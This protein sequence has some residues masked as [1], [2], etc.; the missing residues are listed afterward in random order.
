ML[1]YRHYERSRVVPCD[2]CRVNFPI[3]PSNVLSDIK[4]T[5]I[6]ITITLL[7]FSIY[8]ATL[9]IPLPIQ[10]VLRVIAFP[11]NL[12]VQGGGKK[13]LTQQARHGGQQGRAAEHNT[14]VTQTPSHLDQSQH[15]HTGLTQNLIATQP[16]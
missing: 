14:A 11:A 1:I 12:A 15:T 9:H 16:S 10:S 4:T 8:S 3:L 7:L 13:H 6:I 2:I 5:P